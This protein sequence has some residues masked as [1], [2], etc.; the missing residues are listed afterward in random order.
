MHPEPYPTE[1]QQKRIEELRAEFTAR[2]KRETWITWILL[3]LAMIALITV[4]I[5]THP[6]SY[7]YCRWGADYA[8][9]CTE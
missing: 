3:V 8:I 5:A 9:S 2:Q 6:P 7:V 4:G 1:A